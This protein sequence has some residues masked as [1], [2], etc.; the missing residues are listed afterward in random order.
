MINKIKKNTVLFIKIIFI[1]FL[2]IELVLTAFYHFQVKPGFVKRQQ[3]ESF[4]YEKSENK[5]LGYQLKKKFSYINPNQKSITINKYGIREKTNIKNFNKPIIGLIGDSV[6]FGHVQSDDKTI[7]YYMQ[8]AL[9]NHKIL[10]LGVPGY[11]LEQF[12]EH[13]KGMIDIYEIKS[14]FFILNLND[15]ATRNTLSEGAD[16]GLYRMY[17]TPKIKT[18]FFFNKLVYRLSKGNP[19]Q[20]SISSLNYY[21]LSFYPNKDKAFKNLLGL[22]NICDNNKIKFKTFIL[23]SGVA[24][25]RNDYKLKSM[26]S[27]II[28]NLEEN[29]INVADLTEY[30]SK[31]NFDDTDHL[32]ILGN[33]ILSKLLSDEIKNNN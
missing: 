16:S 7:S 27:L 30:L 15:F 26:H 20:V 4:Y 3:H 33:K 2:I 1:N 5:K 13:L 32:D 11:S 10:N 28:D 19:T 17:V 23:P 18:F 25:Q 29:N 31:N 12:E 24:Y 14:L 8:E 6:I 9:P 22:K 21:R